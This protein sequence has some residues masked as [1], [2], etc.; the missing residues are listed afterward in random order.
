MYSLADGAYQHAMH[1]NEV[2][3]IILFGETGSG[4][5]TNYLHIIDHLL[6]LGQNSN[7]NADRITNAIKLIHVF[8]HAST[9]SNSN[10]TRCLLRTEVTYGRTG[11]ASGAIFGVHLLEKTRVSCVDL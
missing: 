8:T 5:T 10:S 6:Y 3:Q 11:N 4:K 7:I 2:Q 1:H 9:P